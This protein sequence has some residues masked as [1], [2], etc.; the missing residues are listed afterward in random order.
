MRVNGPEKLRLV[1]KVFKW[2]IIARRPLTIDELKEAIVVSKT[3]KSLQ[4]SRIDA[5]DGTRI[6]HACSNLVLFDRIDWTVR[7]CH[8]T[9]KQFLLDCQVSEFKEKLAQLRFPS[10]D[11]AALDVEIGEKCIAY[12]NFKDFE[13]EIVPTRRIAL[14]MNLSTLEPKSW[15]TPLEGGR[16]WD[17]LLSL[18]SA[19]Q[20]RGPTTSYKVDLGRHRGWILP[21]DALRR[22]HHLLNYVPQFWTQHCANLNEDSSV[23]DMFCHLLHG[24]KLLFSFRPWEDDHMDINTNVSHPE[25][26][27]F[28]WGIEKVVPSI[29]RYL[30]MPCYISDWER[31]V[32]HPP[33]SV[34]LVCMPVNKLTLCY[35]SETDHGTS[36][37]ARACESGDVNLV[38]ILC[39]NV[40]FSNGFNKPPFFMILLELDLPITV[41][42]LSPSALAT[43]LKVWC[44]MDDMLLAEKMAFWGKA[45]W[46]AIQS[47]DLHKVKTLC[48]QH[49]AVGIPLHLD[50][51]DRAFQDNP[52][53]TI[54]DVIFLAVSEGHA[55]MLWTL[56]SIFHMQD[57]YVPK[58]AFV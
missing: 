24:R 15:K 17:A 37:L 47:A 36:P 56:S 52:R 44:T 6:I 23:W 3:D 28:H 27:L 39:C 20:A 13:T 4:M 45:L 30:S 12:L 32:M 41:K 1:E 2:I 48:N 7:F 8:H 55:E 33:V 57:R 9:V 34:D 35:Y 31:S 50:L 42:H 49:S 22:K 29:L 40:K 26:G 53:L 43:L 21:S 18:R 10:F 58:C 25:M 14:D 16:T 11:L 46:Y 19:R 51:E 54:E 38:R 5:S